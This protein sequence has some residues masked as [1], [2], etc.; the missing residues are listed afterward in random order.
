MEK[1]LSHVQEDSLVGVLVGNRI[2]ILREED[3]TDDGNKDSTRN[4]Q[5]HPG[6]AVETASLSIGRLTHR[7]EANDDVRLTKVAEEP[8]QVTDDHGSGD[9]RDHIEV[10]RVFNTG[11]AVRIFR[12]EGEDLRRVIQCNQRHDRNDQQCREHHQALHHV[13]VGH[14]KEATDKG[15]DN[16]DGRD[17]D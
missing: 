6:D 15:V 11:G 17:D 1:H 14:C 16:G 5:E 8:S 9:A 4:G 2:I 13:G 10:L 7:H 12:S 3:R